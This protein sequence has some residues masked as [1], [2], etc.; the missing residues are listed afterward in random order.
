MYFKTNLSE[1][2]LIFLQYREHVVKNYFF[3]LLLLFFFRYK[4]LP[5]FRTN[6]LVSSFSLSNITSRRLPYKSQ[7]RAL[8]RKV[9]KD[10]G[11]PIAWPDDVLEWIG[12]LIDD[13]NFHEIS[14]LRKDY[15]RKFDSLQN[16]ISVFYY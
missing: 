5:H 8:L 2:S 15:V 6:S 13:M 1:S 11:N 14:Y 12:G 3:L 7:R 16:G 10:Y 4:I 9:E